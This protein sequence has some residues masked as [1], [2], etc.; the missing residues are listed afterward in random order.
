MM[1]LRTLQT[2]KKNAVCEIRVC[3]DDS[4]K[5]KSRYTVLAVDDHDTVRK[6][7]AIYDKAENVEEATYLDMYSDDGRFYIVYP[8]IKERPLF[9]FYVGSVLDIR[10]C[11]EICINLIIA[12]MTSNLPWPLL[13]LV[14]T[15]GEINLAR[16]NTVTLGYRLD[17]AG[18]DET[19]TEAD[20]VTECAKILIKL[21]EPKSLRRAN[22]YILLTKKTEKGIYLYFTDLYKDL[23]AAMAPVRKKGILLR[24]KLWFERNKDTIFKV[25]LRVSIVLA[26][27]VILTFVTN[28][29]FGDVPWLRLFTR[30]FEKIGLESLLQ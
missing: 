1:K 6:V 22:S 12:C 2:V 25:L 7:I 27:F 28:L 16:D 4:K 11:E 9:D 18:L 26:V 3:E 24:F 29:I 5:V 19:K 10:E 13:Y 21:L 8:Y 20:C 30:N 23:K 17:L 15:Q 14:L